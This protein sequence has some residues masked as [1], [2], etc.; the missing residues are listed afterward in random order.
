MRNRVLLLLWLALLL[1]SLTGDWKPQS[2]AASVAS[3]ETTDLVASIEH[4]Y[5]PAPMAYAIYE[6]PE[7]EIIPV[8]AF[9]IHEDINVEGW[10][11]SYS[12]ESRLLVCSVTLSNNGEAF[13]TDVE[14]EMIYVIAGKGYHLSSI[15]CRT[16][17]GIGPGK[18][19]TA[20][21]RL[22]A[23]LR[24]LGPT[25]TYL[26]GVHSVR[27]RELPF[28]GP[29]PLPAN[30]INVTWNGWSPLMGF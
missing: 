1:P 4:E 3:D 24:R 11:F 19:I 30:A 13:L 9:D 18:F 17:R 28:F 26:L 27:A 12:S 23:S 14:W 16:V 8:P 15:T 7:I 22:P 6:L 29:K 2:G 10:S 20:S 21:V 5:D 25:D